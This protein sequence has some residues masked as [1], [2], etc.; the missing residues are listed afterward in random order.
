MLVLFLLKCQTGSYQSNY[1]AALNYCLQKPKHHPFINHSL[2]QRRRRWDCQILTM[3][4]GLIVKGHSSAA[5][6]LPRIVT[7]K[8]KERKKSS[9]LCSLP[10]VAFSHLPK[11]CNL[12]RCRLI[13][14]FTTSLAWGWYPSY[15]SSF[16]LC[17][18]TSACGPSSSDACF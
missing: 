4:D 13:W 10:P 9:H 7:L 11:P 17:P 3:P 15:V 12:R 14:H 6:Q 2:M 8:G 1:T 5:C 18:Q 16:F